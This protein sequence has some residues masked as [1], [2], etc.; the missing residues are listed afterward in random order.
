[1]FLLRNKVNTRSEKIKHEHD[2]LI[3]R[4]TVTDLEGGRQCIMCKR[5]STPLVSWALSQIKTFTE[6]KICGLF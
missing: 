4:L 3:A 1:M 5:F 6:L 2:V